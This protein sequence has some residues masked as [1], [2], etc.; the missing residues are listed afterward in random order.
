MNSLRNPSFYISKFGA[1]R[2]TIKICWE[3]SSSQSTYK[4]AKKWD[5]YGR[6][7]LNYTIN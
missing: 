1:L 3:D 2:Q 4:T 7:K 6:E 5:K